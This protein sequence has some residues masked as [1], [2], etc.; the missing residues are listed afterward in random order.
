MAD[1]INRGSVAQS[2]EQR[3]EAPC[4]PVRFRPG[5]PLG[6]ASHHR[7]DQGPM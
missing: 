5:P 7:A 6:I 1:G 4:A 3:I 2:V